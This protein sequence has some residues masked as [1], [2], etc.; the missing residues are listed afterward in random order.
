[1]KIVISE[2]TTDMSHLMELL[3]SIEGVKGLTRFGRNSVRVSGSKYEGARVFLKKN[4]IVIL[5]D[6]SSGASHRAFNLIIFIGGI[7]IPYMIYGIFFYPRIYRFKK[8][9]RN[10]LIIML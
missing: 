7:I 4:R 1:M 3:R 10:N 5:A 2:K 8:H 9:I 6:F